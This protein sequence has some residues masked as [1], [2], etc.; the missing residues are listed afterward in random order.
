MV[1]VFH[2]LEV[3]SGMEI[4]HHSSSPD[5][6]LRNW[7]RKLFTVTGK[8][9]HTYQGSVDPPVVD[10]P[11]SFF[12]LFYR[13]FSGKD[14]R[15]WRES[16][17]SETD[18]QKW[19]QCCYFLIWGVGFPERLGGS[20]PQCKLRM[21]PWALSPGNHTSKAVPRTSKA[22]PRAPCWKVIFVKHESFPAFLNF[23]ACH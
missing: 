14:R 16:V 6:V 4:R 18:P 21:P 20:R 10:C 17:G 8:A 1:S 11:L 23:T 12:N 15:W 13:G 3:A 9:L 2:L 22:F 19:W 5:E 7:K